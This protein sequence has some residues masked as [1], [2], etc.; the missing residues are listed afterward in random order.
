MFHMFD[1]DIACVSSECCKSR[2]SVPLDGLIILEL[3]FECDFCMI[4][5]LYNK[6]SDSLVDKR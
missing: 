1:L 6:W 3:S 5:L 2:F 4:K